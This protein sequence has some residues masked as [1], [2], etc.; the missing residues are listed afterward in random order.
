MTINTYNGKI[1]KIVDL[2]PTAR[3][4]TF[5]LDKPI[6]FKPGSFVNLFTTVDGAKVRRAYS[7]SSDP[8]E[9]Q[10]I[11]LS[12][13]KAK[14]GIVSPIFWDSTI[15]EQEFSIMGPLGVNTSDKMTHERIFLFAYGIGISVIKSILF[16]VLE[17]DHIKEVVLVTGNRSDTELLYRE[18]LDSLANE[19][20]KLTL[21]Y[22]LSESADSAYPYQGYIQDNI[23]D[24][25]FAHSDVYICGPTR[26]C[27]SLI[28]TIEKKHPVDTSIHVEKFG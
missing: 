19:Y 23:D 6:D 10:E 9:K 18:Y 16:D 7:L 13:R 17:R 12:I 5:S 8:K 24:L 21:R 2:S 25:D 27:E 3:E 4:V 28:E 20:P 11:S 22:V 1:K 15:H 14:A 26:A